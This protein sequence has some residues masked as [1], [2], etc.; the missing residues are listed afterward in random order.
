MFCEKCGNQ[1]AD[2]VAFCPTCGAPTARPA[3]GTTP[4]P[5]YQQSAYTQPQQPPVQAP[6][7]PPVQPGY[8]PQ[9][10]PQVVPARPNP[11][12][13]KL[14]A[15]LKDFFSPN[16]VKGIGDAAQSTTAEWLFP[17][18]AYVLLFAV[19][20]PL[21]VKG[22]V[23]TAVGAAI[24]RYVARLFG[25]FPLFGVSLPVAIVALAMLVLGLFVQLR[26]FHK[27]EVSFSALMNVVA[28]ASYPVILAFLCN[29]VLS[30]VW[31]PLCLLVFLTAVFMQ[32]VLLYVGMQKAAKLE[33]SPYFGFS[34]AIFV[35]VAVITVV[36]AVVY[37]AY[38]E[39]L[40]ADGTSSL[41]SGAGSLLDDLI[42][43]F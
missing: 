38:L 13:E 28:Y 27:K 43:L 32:V 11:I 30:F 25:F 9:G 7:Q 5:A 33:K 4:P 35:C 1:M 21:V 2:G 3:A 23:K 41:L 17:V 40:I 37:K 12:V 16:C 39:N 8:P 10:Y 22:L 20:M 42:D 19:S 31:A 29:I 6:Y 14:G 24:G 26:A 15:R 18:I 34:L 36:A